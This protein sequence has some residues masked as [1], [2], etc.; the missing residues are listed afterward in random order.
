MGQARNDCHPGNTRDVRRPLDRRIEKTLAAKEIK[1]LFRPGF[2]G[3]RP[4]ADP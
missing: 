1:E 4:Q 2:D 3:Q